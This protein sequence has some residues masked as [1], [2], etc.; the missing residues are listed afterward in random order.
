M[1]PE[2]VRLRQALY[3]YNDLRSVGDCAGQDPKASTSLTLPCDEGDWRDV[4]VTWRVDSKKIL[5]IAGDS[6]CAQGR[7]ITADATIPGIAG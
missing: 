7:A 1:R 5:K 6:E 2:V 3:Q 4:D